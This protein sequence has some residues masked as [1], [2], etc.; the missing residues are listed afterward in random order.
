MLFS[1]LFPLFVA[2]QIGLFIDKHFLFT[3]LKGFEF[4]SIN[5]GNSDNIQNWREFRDISVDRD[6]IFVLEGIL[7][8]VIEYNM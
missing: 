4:S 2:A 5:I 1:L 7:N 3:N 6:S 8:T